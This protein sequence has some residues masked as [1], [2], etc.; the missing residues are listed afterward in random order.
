MNTHINGRCFISFLAVEIKVIKL[1][2]LFYAIYIGMKIYCHHTC[3]VLVIYFVGS[4]VV[5]NL[6]IE[7]HKSFLSFR[8]L[9]M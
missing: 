4:K 6:E 1:D 2:T 5:L 9:N 7:E 8:K 3:I